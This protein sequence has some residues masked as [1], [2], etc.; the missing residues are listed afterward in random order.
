M[1]DNHPEWAKAAAE[2]LSKNLP[3]ARDRPGWNDMAST[4]YQIGCMGLVKLGFADATDWG[5]IPKDHPELPETLPRWDDI[6]I[7]VL[8][9]AQQQ[10]K[11]SYL[12]PDGS[13]QPNRIGSRF[14]IMRKDPSP[15]PTPNIAARFGLGPALCQPEVLKLLEQLGLVADGGW[16]EEAV[17]VLWRTSPKNWSLDYAN[18]DRFLDAIQKAVASMPD[19][20]A[21]EI[22]KLIVITEDDIDALINRHTKMIAEGREK[23]GPKARLGEVPSQEQARRFLEF[24]RR[25]EL[26]WL[27]FR[28]WRID[29]GWVSEKATNCAIDIFHDRLAIS[30]RKAVLR[31]LHPAKSQFFE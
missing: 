27:L 28:H 23:Y 15:P 4:A 31:R 3:K 6:C 26:D 14:V 20:V 17:F 8:W 16:T 24:S 29:D 7:S 10:S 13:A 19:E 12:L 25:N 22:S 9:L 18:D 21:S 5:A 1:V 30:M 2:F 11:L